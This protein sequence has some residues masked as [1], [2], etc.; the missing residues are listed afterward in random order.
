M[1][2][3]Q[4]QGPA[5]SSSRSRR[6]RRLWFAEWED[7]IALIVGILMIVLPWELVYAIDGQIWAFTGLGVIVIISS[8]SEI[9][10]VRHHQVATAT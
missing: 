1:G 6:F 9:W 3:R 7:W 10:M 4:P 2:R 5:A 8:L